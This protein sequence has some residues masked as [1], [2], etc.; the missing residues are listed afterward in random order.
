MRFLPIKS[1]SSTFL[2]LSCCTVIAVGQTP[3][4]SPSDSNGPIT[5]G[6][7]VFTVGHS[8]HAW[9]GHLLLEL[10]RSAGY[11]DAQM[12]VMS[13]GGSTVLECW[14]IPNAPKRPKQPLVNTAKAALTSGTVDVLTLSPIWMPDEG[15]DDFAALALEHNPDVRV[16]V[17]EFW[18]PNDTYEPKYPL[19]VHKQP[20]V[21]HDDATVASLTKA[22]DAYNHDVEQYV[23]G[24]NKKL[25]KDVVLIVP[26]GAATLALREKI[27]NG[28]CPAIQKQSELYRD[29][30]GHPTSPL[31]MLSAY[32]HFAVI[33]RH[34]PVGLPMPTQLQG[35][36]KNDDL[37]HLL[38]QLAWDAVTHHP[39]TGV[40]AAEP[41]TAA[42][43]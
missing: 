22:Y 31:Q 5:H 38:Q 39:M 11:N 16:T 12:G 28:Q 1:L 40:S 15:I 4:V 43:Q 19:D 32:C 27:I 25:G 18:L 35:K 36:Y 33:Y 13:L 8:F 10:A 9:V 20:T 26:V 29:P 23:A 21:N 42:A 6:L 30:W 34:S 24:V 17:Q 37:N 7:R 3:A 2:A 14:Q 41:A